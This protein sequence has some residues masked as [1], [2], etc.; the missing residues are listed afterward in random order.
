MKGY[1]GICKGQAV[2][3]KYLE[4]RTEH[5]EMEA[6]SIKLFQIQGLRA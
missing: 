3:P 6:G 2:G 1:I 4:E 5:P